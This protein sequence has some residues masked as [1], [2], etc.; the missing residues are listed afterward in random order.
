MTAL[1]GTGG[2]F[3]LIVRRDRVLLALWVVGL[4]VYALLALSFSQSA[5]PTAGDRQGYVAAINGNA[6]FLMLEG[7]AYGSSVGAVASWWMGDILWVTGLV[8]VLVVIRHTR[9][10]EETGRRELLGAT[11]VGRHAQLTAALGVVLASNVAL[12]LLTTVAMLARG[13]PVAGSIALGLKFAAVGC[14]FAA[15]AAVAAQVTQSAAAARGI[16]VAVLGAAF[17]LRAAG[18]AGTT[19]DGASWLSWLSPLAWAH[20][21]RPF[22]G[23]RWWLLLLF[24]GAVVLLAAAAITLSGRRDVG[25]GVFKPRLGQAAAS[26]WLRGPVALAWR[27]HRGRMFAWAAGFAVFGAVLLGSAKAAADLFQQGSV[28]RDMFKPLGGGAP[29]GASDTFLAGTMGLF[30]LLAASYAVTAVLLL[31]SEEVGQRAEPVLA[32]SVGRRGWA[33]SHLVF[34]LLGPAVAL[35]S[36]GLAGGLVYGVSVGD[37]A[38]QLPRVLAAAIVQLPAVWLLTGMTMALFGLAPRVAFGAWVPLAVFVFLWFVG[39]M[40]LQ[41]SPMLLDISPFTHLPKLPGGAM[42]TAP[43]LWLLAIAAALAVAGLAGLRRRDVGSA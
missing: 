24:A 16:A 32:T 35:A 9:A 27:L 8:S 33:I 4:V 34:A 3:R 19:G 14:A 12:A 36:A 23:E 30:G 26:P 37:L 18:D 21:I 11:V 7:R 20:R 25:V 41:L 2:V 29:A 39:T 22:A 17:L 40:F 10:E 28:I 43:L 5:N 6:G 31:R 42:T 13:L 15:V 38:G 1:A